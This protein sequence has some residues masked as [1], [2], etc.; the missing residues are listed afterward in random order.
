ME[1]QL[2]SEKLTKRKQQAMQTRKR[3]LNCALE[4]FEK[5]GYDSVTIQEI[6]DTA[7]TSVGSIYRYFKSKEEMAA[8]NSEPL[9]DIYH[10]YFQSLMHDETYQSLSALKKLEL[11]YLFVQKA[12]SSY[13]NLRSIY[14]YSLRKSASNLYLTNPER[15]LYQD[16]RQLLDACR[17]EHSIRTDLS[18]E[19]YFDLFLQSSR[20]MLLDWLLRNK[21]FDFEM[22]AQLWWEILRSFIQISPS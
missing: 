11:Y 10:E 8:Q 4:L 14:T 3:I 6:A 7:H 17:Q 12:V 21:N 2:M 16:Y 18:N 20:G 1:P 19:D 13:S 9:D 5:K 22:Q 15:E